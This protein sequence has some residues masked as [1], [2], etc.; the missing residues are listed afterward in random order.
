MTSRVPMLRSLALLV[1]LALPALAVGDEI[2][3]KNG[4]KVDGHVQAL[5][6]GHLEVGVYTGQHFG[7]FPAMATNKLKFSNVRS[8]KFDGRDDFFAI[9]KKNEEVLDARVYELSKG[10]F[11]VDGHEPIAASAVKALVPSKPNEEGNK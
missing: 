7:G 1:V 6:D 10:K 8:I 2:T 11:Q 3:M 5:K 4:Q 9:V